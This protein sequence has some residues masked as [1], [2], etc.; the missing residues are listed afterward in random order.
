MGR[1]ASAAVLVAVLAA[2][3]G[4]SAR[5]RLVTASGSSCLTGPHE[6]MRIRKTPGTAVTSHRPANPH[7]EAYMHCR[8]ADADGGEPTRARR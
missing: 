2:P 4:A 1:A 6:P 3:T 7:E 8:K 5:E